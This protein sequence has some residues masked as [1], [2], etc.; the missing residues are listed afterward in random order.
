VTPKSEADPEFLYHYLG[1]LRGQLEEIAPQSAQK[2]IT[3]GI[4]TKVPVPK[5]AL[6]EQRRIVA[7]LDALQ[8]KVD[9]LKRLQAEPAAELD[10]LPP[11][12]KLRRARLRALLDGAW[13]PSPPAQS[14]CALSLRKSRLECSQRARPKGEL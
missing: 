13:T 7:E 12:P 11:S 3:L 10:A 4:L 5:L 2:N 8:A 9:A 1:Y 14:G 6:A